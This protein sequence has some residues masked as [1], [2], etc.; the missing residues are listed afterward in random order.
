MRDY[1]D[2][3]RDPVR[4]LRGDAVMKSTTSADQAI[5]RELA[6][7]AYQL[8]FDSPQIQTLKQYASIRSARGDHPPSVAAFASNIWVW[9]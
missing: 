2:I 9:Y 7:L 1:P 5:L 8:W 6:D 3:P 4:G